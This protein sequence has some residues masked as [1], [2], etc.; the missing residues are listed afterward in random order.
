[1]DDL[2]KE[3]S[4]IQWKLENVLAKVCI[5]TDGN[6]I[7]DFREIKQAITLI[8]TLRNKLDS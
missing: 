1:M 5:K 7:T 6:L 3:L 8:E 4:V 2:I